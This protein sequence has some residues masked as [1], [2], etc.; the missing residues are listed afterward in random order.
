MHILHLTTFVQGGAGR[1][2]LSLASGQAAVGHQVSVLTS[3]TGTPGYDNYPEYLEAMVAAGVTVSMID[4]L[5]DRRPQAHLPV[6]RYL[7]DMLDI[8]P[9]DILHA[10]AGV[11]AALASAAVQ[12]AGRRIP[13]L[14]TMHGWGITKTPAQVARDVA[15]MNAVDRVVV[16]AQ[17]SASL[18]EGLGVARRHM[19][20]V[21]YGVDAG[22]SDASP[23]AHLE[24]LR[25]WRRRGDFVVCCVGTICARKNQVLLV[26]ALAKIPD[27]VPV[28]AVF[29]GDGPT[30]ELLAS[31]RALGVADRVEVTGYQPEARRFMRE[32][33][34]LV[35]PS[36]AEGQPLSVLEAFCD[37]VPV[38]ASN[39]P[40]LVELVE[41]GR[42][43]WLFPSEDAGALAEVL[44]RAACARGQA[45]AMAAHARARH[46]E[47]FTVGHMVAGYMQEYEKAS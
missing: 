38:A 18:L 22:W 28:R 16:P 3:R 35:L 5:F 6:E 37:G 32:S 15:T 40:E 27:T 33:H 17:A 34:L 24:R 46:R 13:V 47:R 10:H 23:D 26:E 9:I 31:A 25:S 12:R 43:G 4:S 14:Q 21:P 1:A 42:T 36:R 41:D 45:R 44:T 2:M 19:A 11:P 7:D 29:V 20:I 39:I 8:M 30:D